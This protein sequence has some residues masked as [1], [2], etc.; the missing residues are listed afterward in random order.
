MKQKINSEFSAGTADE[1]CTNADSQHVAPRLHKAQCYK[2][3][4]LELWNDDCQIGM[5]NIADNS[6]D[7]I[8]TDPPYLY[9]KN[10]KLEREFEEQ[11]FFS[12]CKRVLKK[13]GFIVLFGRGT[14]FYR[15]NTILADLGF[16]FKEEIIWDKCRTTSPVTPISR[17]HESIVIY[18]KGGGKINRVK[19]P[20]LEK[21]KHEPSKIK[22]TI[23]RIATTFGNRETFKLLKKYYE[24][25]EKVY[26]KTVDKHC[27][28]RAKN[29]SLN[30]NRT[31]VF[32][33]GLEEGIVEQSIIK[34]VS[35]HYNF[36]H[37]TQKP[38]KLLERLLALTTKKE[39]VVLDAFS[40]SGSTA[41]ACWNTGRKFI[42]FE[43]DEEYFKASVE[44]IKKETASPELFR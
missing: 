26:E 11:L 34:E 19:V 1:Q 28:T 33:I 18:T 25:G 44:R 22:E 42:G 43:I 32:A 40:G 8:L 17:K 14:S 4:G 20:F 3:P 16:V 29:S 38:I 13:S 6:I 30:I 41:L 27:V 21:Y 39:Y 5:K 10:Q 12:E 15:W 7:C 2:Q 37:P 23:N 9:L 36:I 35:D 31:I 24:S